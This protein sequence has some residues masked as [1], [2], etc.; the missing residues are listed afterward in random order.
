MKVIKAKL[1]LVDG[2]ME[3]MEMKLLLMKVIGGEIIV[4]GS[5]GGL[6]EVMKVKLLLIEVVEAKSLMMKMM[7]DDGEIVEIFE[8]I[9]N[10][11]KH[12]F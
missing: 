10:H 7:I 4:D 3:V 5:D 1:L 9:K 6:M 8:P 12:F 2:I 11:L